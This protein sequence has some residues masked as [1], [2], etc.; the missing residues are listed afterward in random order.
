M[1]SFP[2][3]HPPLAAV[4]AVE[5]MCVV[6]HWQTSLRPERIEIIIIVIAHF[7]VAYRGKETGEV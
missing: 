3:F 6:F 7:D 5:L 2:K 1:C 4:A